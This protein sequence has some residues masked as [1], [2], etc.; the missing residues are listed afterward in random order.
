M[1]WSQPEHATLA[2][3][4]ID[5]V[6]RLEHLDSQALTPHIKAKGCETIADLLLGDRTVARVWKF[7]PG[8]IAPSHPH[9]ILNRANAMLDALLRRAEARQNSASAEARN[10]SRAAELDPFA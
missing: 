5:A 9:R 1:N 7:E 3:A 10:R 6:V 4:L 2:N 8:S